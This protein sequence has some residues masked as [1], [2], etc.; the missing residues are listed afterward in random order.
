MLLFLI[1]FIVLM[2]IGVPI[3]VSMFSSSILYIINNGINPVIA[4]QRIFAGTN[5]FVLLAVPGF[6]LAASIMNTGGITNRIFNFAD[7]CVGHITGGLG[8]ANILASVIFAGMSGSATADAAGLGAIELRAMKNA[9]YP[10]DFS[11]AV[12]GASAI[13]GP[14]IPPSI[15]MVVYAVASSTSVGKL[16][17]AGVIP[18]ILLAL[19]MSIYV[20]FYSKKKGFA[21]REKASKK[22]LFKAIKEGFFSLMA[23]IIILGSIVIGI[24][25]PTE[26]AIIGVVYSL[27]LGFCYK[28]VS[29]RNLWK[30]LVDTMRTVAPVLFILCGASLFAYVL[31][32]EQVPQLLA[33]K[34]MA[35]SP[36][37]Y[38]FLLIVNALLLIVGCFMDSTA[39]I[40]ILT[41]VFMPVIKAFGI[42]PIHFGIIMVVNIMIGFVTPPVGVGLY[43]LSVISKVR[44]E[45]IVKCMIPF[46][47][48]M[49]IM[50]LI[51]SFVPSIAT[52]LPYTLGNL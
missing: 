32:I 1:S 24:C 13:I 29:V 22:E 35:I 10:D 7:K 30:F 47:I 15:P 9:G 51:F 50:V 8:H 44:F 20:Y 19:S 25:T 21:T 36:N 14:I 46:I 49:I 26:A 45:D 52:F 41:P 38:V 40:I 48:V 5:S 11:I 28:T 18:G 43:V 12:T 6:V 39:A 37:K 17:M 42:D 31:A 3:G 4:V 27:I 23:P 16:F 33:N 2:V 34:F